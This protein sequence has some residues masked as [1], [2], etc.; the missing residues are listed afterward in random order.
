MDKVTAE[1]WGDRPFSEVKPLVMAAVRQNWLALKQVSNEEVLQLLWKDHDVLL[2]A[3]RQSWRAMA[4]AP[5]ESWNDTKAVLEAV[6][7]CWDVLQ[8]C[9]GSMKK[10]MWE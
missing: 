8:K 4:N 5:K 2:A 7:Q 3:V 6:E 1:L 10:K 9:P